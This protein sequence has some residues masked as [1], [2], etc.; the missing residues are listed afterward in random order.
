VR[1][2]RRAPPTLEGA[3]AH[4]LRSFRLSAQGCSRVP[5]SQATARY[6]VRAQ[7]ALHAGPYMQV[8]EPP[9][10]QVAHTCINSQLGLESC[11]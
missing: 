11:K 6:R 7:V 1:A 4:A 2:A 9:V 10:K 5:V 8:N 3:D